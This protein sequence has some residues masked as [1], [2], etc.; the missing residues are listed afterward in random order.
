MREEQVCGWEEFG[1]G[2][3]KPGSEDVQETVS[4]ESYLLSP[5]H[6]FLSVPQCPSH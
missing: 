2:G 4:G 3:L 1:G 5:E 6:L